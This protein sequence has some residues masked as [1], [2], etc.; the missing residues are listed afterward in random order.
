MVC[1]TEKTAHTYVMNTYSSAQCRAVD[2]SKNQTRDIG[3]AQ[4]GG[5][6]RSRR[7]ARRREHDD[8]LW[9]WMAQFV[10]AAG[11]EGAR[12]GYVF[13]TGDLGTGYYRRAILC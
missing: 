5:G 6:I 1:K 3:C 8:E 11:F 12:E 7:H 4:V 2:L 9:T 13:T 10:A